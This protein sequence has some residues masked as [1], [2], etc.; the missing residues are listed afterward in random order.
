MRTL[1]EVTRI[2]EGE[3]T[4]FLRQ[5]LG[6]APTA[7]PEDIK[8]AYKIKVKQVHPDKVVEARRAA[9][10]AE[11]KLLSAAY[12]TLSNAESRAYYDATGVQSSVSDQEEAE[13]SSAWMHPSAGVDNFDWKA[14]SLLDPSYDLCCTGTCLK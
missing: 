11:F 12:E 5:V 1:Y 4:A 14:T 13:A 10:E 9:A 3:M 7:S 2:R 8:R 6:V